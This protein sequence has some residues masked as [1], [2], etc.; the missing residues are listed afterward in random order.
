LEQQDLWQITEKAYI[1]N[2]LFQAD[3]PHVGFATVLSVYSCPADP[4]TSDVAVLSGGLRV[5]LTSYL[6]VEGTNQ[7][8]HD[9]VLF[10][11]SNIC[12][13]DISD[14][15]SNTLMVGGRPP[16][17]AE[18]FG[19]W[20]G[21]WGQSKDGSGDSVLGA[22]ERNVW[23]PAASC[24]KGPY[25]YGPG[26]VQNQCDLF[27]FWSLHTGG[28]NFLLADGSVHFLTYSADPIMPALTTRAGGEAV[29]LPD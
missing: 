23:Q 28:A 26:Q 29:G 11:D 15:L 2:S 25:H 27:H 8:R 1:L 19:W 20:Y 16:N 10:L 18:D 12:L 4:R 17:F 3:P 14:G 9:G 24:P 6:G 22:R 13:T 5:A 21:G 7:W